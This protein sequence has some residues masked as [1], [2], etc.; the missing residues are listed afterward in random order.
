MIKECLRELNMKKNISLRFIRIRTTIVLIVS[1]LI[2][3]AFIHVQFY[4]QR[5]EAKLKAEYTAE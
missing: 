1:F 4:N 5:K 3:N 2:I